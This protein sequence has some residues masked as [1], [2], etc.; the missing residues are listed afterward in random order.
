MLSLHI[1]SIHA[2][3][4]GIAKKKLI[5]P[6]RAIMIFQEVG[7]VAGDFDGIAWR[8]RGKDNLSI[9]LN[10]AFMDSTLA[11]AT[12]PPTAVVTWIHS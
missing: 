1:S 5:L 3:K 12:G 4:K 7:L 10:E 6:P 2:K 8:H 9:L 11:Y